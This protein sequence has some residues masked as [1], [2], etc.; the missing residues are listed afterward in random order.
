MLNL[1]RSFVSS[2]VGAAVTLL[3]LLLI[4]FAFAAGDV[5]G[6]RSMGLNSGDRVATVGNQKVDTAHLSQAATN[7]VDNLKQQEPRLSMKSFLAQGGLDK[8]LDDLLGR[9]ALWVFGQNN[10][11]VASD[12]LIDSEIAKIP[13]FRGLDGKFSEDIFRQLLAQ[14]HI[15]EKAV[16]EDL[17]QSL[18]ARQ[19]LDPASIGASVPR[20]LALR[21]AGLLREKR[22]GAVALLPSPAFAPKTPPSD[23][24]LADYY[25][26]NRNHF[27]RPERRVIRY[28]TFGDEVLK[29]LATPTD[30][31][32]ATFYNANRA[33]YS[34]V[35]L[36]RLTQLI[37][38]TQAAAQAVI[39][40]VAGGKTL[41][42]AAGE[43]GLSATK[44]GP[45]DKP[46]FATANSPAV[47]DAAFAASGGA[48]AA[49]ARS[50]IGWHVV[51]VDAIE[52][53]PERSLSQVRGEIAGQLTAVKRRKALSDLTARIEDQFDNGANI[54]DAAKDLG[55][56][57][58]QTP[59]LTADGKSYENPAETMPPVL[60]KIAPTAF[61]ME[62]RK[63]QLAEAEPNKTFVIYDVSQIAPS[64]APPLP[65]IKQDVQAA[66][67]LDKGSAA[68]K[69]TAEKLLTQTHKGVSLADA[70][71]ALGLPLPRVEPVNMDRSQLFANGNHPAP[72]LLLLFSMA[73]GT[74]KLLPISGNRGWFVVSLRDIT[75][76][77]LTANDELVPATQRE[78]GQMAG[79]EYAEGLRRAIEAEV[80]VKRN[81]AGIKAVRSQLGG[82][83]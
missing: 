1:F 17:A 7:A 43:K 34:A 46:A 42:A 12:R 32:I 59:T 10:H 22:I 18:V 75:P 61:Q 54:A 3:V 8:V 50:A 36:R 45:I 9:T 21:Y 79:G 44:V 52:R 66:Y 71:A 33:Q 51:H 57:L 83:N 63:P 77:P 58:Q 5:A 16:R 11:I 2:K 62:E 67:L 20:E 76:Q 74:T 27:I 38:P 48:I 41:E 30:A 13:A 15:S 78:L 40:E 35:E 60:G 37:V 55:I 23:K 82:G 69:A 80:T 56:T 81:E 65:E 24:D 53:R 26:A 25:A 29:N 6:L 39:A 4:A 19:I 64:A 31:E 68:A 73:R 14:R 47:A 70:V 28:A 49:P 72:P